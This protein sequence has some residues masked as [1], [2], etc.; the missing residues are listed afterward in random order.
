MI[1]FWFGE[2]QWRSKKVLLKKFSNLISEPLGQKIILKQNF[3]DLSWPIILFPVQKN[4]F[5]TIFKFGPK[6]CLLRIFEKLEFWKTL[7]P[8]NYSDQVFLR[9]FSGNLE[10]QKFLLNIFLKVRSHFWKLKKNSCGQILRNFE[11]KMC[12]SR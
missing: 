8:K 12:P 5:R 10:F 1:F 2:T 3:S 7:W 6:S 9:D 11:L 4:F